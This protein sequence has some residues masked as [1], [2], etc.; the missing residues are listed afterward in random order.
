MK[1]IFKILLYFIVGVILLLIAFLVWFFMFYVQVPKLEIPENINNFERVKLIDQ[2]FEKLHEQKKFNGGILMTEN[3]EVLLMK[4]YGY[5]DYRLSEKLNTHSSFRLASIS[6]QFTASGI[7]LLEENNKIDYN[8]FVSDYITGFPYKNITI[9][10]LLNQTS[11]IP[12]TYMDLAEQEKEIIGILT[13]K[14]VVELLVKHQPKTNFKPNEKYEY[15]NTN[16]ILLARIIELVSGQSFEK[17]MKENIFKPLNMN[18]TRVW[19]LIS[20]DTDFQNKVDGFEIIPMKHKVNKIDPT[21]IDGVAGDGAVFSSLNDFVIWD[22]FWYQNNLISN[23]NLK[24]A[25]QKPTLNNGEKSNYGFG[26]V[27]VNDDVAMHNG[28]WLAS[29]TYSVR[30][31]KKKTSFVLLDNSQNIFFDKIIEELNKK[32]EI[33]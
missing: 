23:E 9:R 1:M 24:N 33:Q 19:N 21:Y 30:N 7:M 6:K 17:Y 3:G 32:T 13:N 11:G 29:N 27:I 26:W 8:D 18:D 12:D 22:K 5:S 20:E 10:H 14:K 25:F 2:W 4:T 16:Y 15:S 28:A 31:I